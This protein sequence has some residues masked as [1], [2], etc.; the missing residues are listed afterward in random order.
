MEQAICALF[1]LL[2]R[3]QGDDLVRAALAGTRSGMKLS[4]EF[5]NWCREALAGK[6]KRKAGQG[7][8]PGSLNPFTAREAIAR[9]RAELHRQ[10]NRRVTQKDALAHILSHR[11]KV[12]GKT[13]TESQWDRAL[14]PREAWVR[15]L[16]GIRKPPRE[17]WVELLRSIKRDPTPSR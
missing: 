9:V 8:P 17:P 11:V 10:S 14:R 6:I 13:W 2:P 15:N 16:P 3:W 4:A 1:P 5:A 12:A 7:R